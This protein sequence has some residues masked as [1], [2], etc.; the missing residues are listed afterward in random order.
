MNNLENF[1]DLAELNELKE[2]YTD[3]NYG[4]FI[5]I[6]HNPDSLK[7]DKYI[8][9]EEAIDLYDKTLMEKC[10]QEKNK[11]EILKEKLVYIK[12]FFQLEDYYSAEN[13]ST[14]QENK[15]VNIKTRVLEEDLEGILDWDIAKAILW[16]E[17]TKKN[18]FIK[19]KLFSFIK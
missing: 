1:L 11:N 4:D 12:A 15:T 18:R 3:L 14:K 9:F 6:F 19:K 2:N 7:M 8:T 16:I 17:K 13:M 10:D 5:L